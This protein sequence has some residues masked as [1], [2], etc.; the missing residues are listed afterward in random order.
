MEWKGLIIDEERIYD[1]ND[2]H[3]VPESMKTIVQDRIILKKGA[4]V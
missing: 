1:A 4:Q 3:C 2:S